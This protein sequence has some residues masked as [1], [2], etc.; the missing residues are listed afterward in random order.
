MNFLNCI[1]NIFEAYG[2]NNN[3]LNFDKLAYDS[4]DLLDN[5][6]NAKIHYL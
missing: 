1:T 4:L 6:D 5:F 2:K 3:N